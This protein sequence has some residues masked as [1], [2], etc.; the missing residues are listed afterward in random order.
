MLITAD[1][2]SVASERRRMSENEISPSSGTH[3]L[4]PG[5]FVN[6]RALEL[7]FARGSG[8]GG[9]AVNKLNTA[10]KL[11]V[12]L[13]DISGLTDA[14]QH[15]L[16]RL[17]GQRLTAGDELLIQSRTHRS[18]LDNRRA[19]LRKLSELVTEAAREPKPRK[20]MRPTKAM[21]ERR[22]KEKKQRSEKKQRRRSSRR[23]EW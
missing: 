8:P 4:A 17:A 14:A 3:E 18:Q 10:V 20:R 5:V 7:T 6:D 21:I 12:S 23:D 13:D 2:R 22:I 1:Q 11:R 16:R 15:R 9:Q 19:C